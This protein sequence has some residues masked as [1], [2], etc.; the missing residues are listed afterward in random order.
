[1]IIEFSKDLNKQIIKANG[2]EVVNVLGRNTKNGKRV[3]QEDFNTEVKITTIKNPSMV[4]DPYKIFDPDE[5]NS[6]TAY[7]ILAL[8]GYSWRIT[9]YDGIS[10]WHDKNV[11]L[12]VWAPSIDTLVVA[13]A[14]R[15]HQSMFKNVKSVIDVGCGSGF[16]GIYA[17]H[18]LTNIKRTMFNDINPYAV[19]CAE[20][21][22]M[23]CDDVKKIYNDKTAKIHANGR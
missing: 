11:H 4:W 2:N 9:R 7:T 14:I 22:F 23:G 1:M 17:Q 21:N 3:F 13:D 10:V 16:L 18:K 12:D 19:M 5:F 20:N 6:T 8:F 15:R